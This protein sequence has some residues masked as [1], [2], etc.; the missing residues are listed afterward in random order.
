MSIQNITHSWF[1]KLSDINSEKII[2]SSD[3]FVAIF[4]D[5]NTI[6]DIEIWENS[7]LEFYGFSN[8]ANLNL[9]FFQKEKSSNLKLNYLFFSKQDKLNRVINSFIKSDNA[10]SNLK[11]IS[12]IWEDSVINI[13]WNIKIDENI[14]NVSWNLLE[15]NIFLSDSGII[16][17]LPKLE[18]A[19]RDV[20][21]SH[22]CRIDKINLQD[23]FYLETRWIDKDFAKNM[24]IEAKIIDLFS[25]LSMY[26]EAFYL[27]LLSKIKKIIN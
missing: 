5:L 20:Q 12:I 16:K 2:I 4:D 1:Y 3:I 10:I 9:D 11:L 24:M 15:E 18:V 8:S 7:K 14:K 21:A 13:D 17:A 27:E 23:L 22:A 19:S 26:D 25:C 6:V